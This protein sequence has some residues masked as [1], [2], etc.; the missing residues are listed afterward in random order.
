VLGAFAPRVATF[1][2]TFVPLPKGL[3]SEWVRAGWIAAVVL[4]PIVVGVVFS[5]RA[6]RAARRESAPVRLLR[7]LPITVGIA[8]AVLVALV[9]VPLR[10]L[11]AIVR[12]QR[13]DH[14]PLVVE[15]DAY[16][17]VARDVERALAGR[18]VLTPS[19]TGWAERAPSSILRVLGGPA[20]RDAVPEQLETWSGPELRVTLHPNGVALRGGELAVTRAHGLLDE[21]M[22]RTRALQTTDAEAQ[23]LEKR[24]HEL[25]HLL[26]SAPREQRRSS[27]LLAR[28]DAIAAD[29]VE[30]EAPYTDWQVVYRQALQLSRALHGSR[31][32]L[33]KNTPTDPEAV[34]H[35]AE[36]EQPRAASGWTRSPGGK[37]TLAIAAGVGVVA[38]ATGALLLGRTPI[39]GLAFAVSKRGRPWL[40]TAARLALALIA[41]R[42]GTRAQGQVRDR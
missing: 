4:V 39:G 12:R 16:H 10:K 38:A 40:T 20:F 41:A 22:A 3:S 34:L 23:K 8:S 9:S 30:L 24:L 18:F 14:V 25:W 17:A 19:T 15:P 27:A 31:P 28:L 13:D 42:A 6:R 21:A 26:D 37:K 32:L 35:D 36:L 7:G 2:L 1:V 29:L 33:A 11:V 5:R